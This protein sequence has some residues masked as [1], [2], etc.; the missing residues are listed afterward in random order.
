MDAVG[1]QFQ[2]AT[3]LDWQQQGLVS[4]LFPLARCRPHRATLPYV[5][6]WG[7]SRRARAKSEGIMA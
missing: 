2:I 5:G 1:H 4:K 7:Q 3:F 6:V